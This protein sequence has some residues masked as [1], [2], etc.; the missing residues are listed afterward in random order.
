MIIAPDTGTDDVVGLRD[1]HTADAAATHNNSNK[2]VQN[3]IRMGSGSEE[4]LTGSRRRKSP[5]GQRL[6]ESLGAVSWAK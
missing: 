1:L 4:T 3:T 2:H 5:H 6:H